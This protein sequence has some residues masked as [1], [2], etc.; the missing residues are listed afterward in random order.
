MSTGGEASAG[1][2]VFIP[3][4]VGLTVNVDWRAALLAMAVLLGALVLLALLIVRDGPAG[5]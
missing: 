3:L 2:L 4:L 1:Q 5:A